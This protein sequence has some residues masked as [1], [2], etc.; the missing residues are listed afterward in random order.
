[1]IRYISYLTVCAAVLIT[2]LGFMGAEDFTSLPYSGIQHH[3]LEFQSFQKNSPNNRLPLKPGDRIVA[4]DGHKIR[5]MNHFLFLI[6]SDTTKKQQQYLFQRQDSTFK[7]K[8]SYIAQPKD[9]LMMMA[10]HMVVGLTFIMVGLVVI[11]KR[12]DILGILFTVNCL[13]FSFILFK[14][15]ITPIPIMQLGG[16]IL[17]DFIL[18]FLPA[19][20]LHFFIIF[21]GEE[22]RRG[23]KREK[24][25]KILYLPPVF[26]FTTSFILAFLNFNAREYID[27][28]KAIGAIVSLYWVLYMALSLIVVVRTYVKTSKVQ[29]IKLRISILGLAIGLIPLLIVTLIKQFSPGVRVP[30]SHLSFILL[31]AISVSFAYSILKHDAFDLGIAFRKG[32]VLII[33]ALLIVIFY[34]LFVNLI[35]Y[36]FSNMIG[37][38]N[39]YLTVGTVA[40]LILSLIPARSG[41]QSFVNRAFH[42]KGRLPTELIIR[43]SR[44]IQSSLTT[45]DVSNFISREMK[46]IFNVDY[47]LFYIGEES[48]NFTL[49]VS[50]PQE[51]RIPLTSLSSDTEFIKIIRNRKKPLMIEYM[52]PLL[53]KNVLD[54]ISLEFI[55]LSAASVIVPLIEHDKMYGFV[56]LPNKRNNVPFSS[57]EEESLEL[58]SERSAAA[59]R[60]IELYGESIEK[61]KLEREIRLASEIQARLLPEKLPQLEGMNLEAR[62][63]SSYKVGGDFYDFLEPTSHSICVGVADVSGKGIPAS[64]LASTLQ[65]YFRAEVSKDVSPS[66]ILESLNKLIFSRSDLNRFATFF[67]ATY[68][69]T[70]GILRYSNG[71]S[72][73]PIVFHPDGSISRLKRG[74]ILIGVENESVYKEG[75]VKIKS[76]DLV[77]IYTDGLIDQENKSGEPFGENRVIEFFKKN[78]KVEI[79]EIMERLFQTVLRFGSDKLKDDMT[80][81]L[82]KRK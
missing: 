10:A 18:L 77:V 53:M 9:K 82:M 26:I 46:T 23:S 32:L 14:R 36:R 50:Y 41:I 55:T 11:I 24:L 39:S 22:I 2:I 6:S 60:N 63:M 45:D 37:I 70:L 42:R 20:F 81:V 80:V 75:I 40:I 43:F 47:C 73:P 13:F 12:K 79:D 48:G 30:Y 44:E 17:Y 38:N 54:R 7:A 61:K 52:D 27:P 29:K 67:C 76:G 8:V 64:L 3:N 15:P 21:P 62:L 34:N 5:N 72:F 33:M 74:G 69:D 4:V 31:S 1:M 56:V 51:K 65:A 58:I 71:G 57:S 49:S 66:N 68:D 59:F 19:F 28:V 25:V 16:E 78:L 35:G